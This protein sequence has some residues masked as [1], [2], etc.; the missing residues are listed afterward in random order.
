MLLYVIIC[1]LKKGD[2]LA[3]VRIDEK[4]L[5]RIQKWLEREENKYQ[6][7]STSAFV[8]SAIYEKLKKEEK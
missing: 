5:K 8:N 2:N 6:H 3:V 4:L 1:Y 7:P